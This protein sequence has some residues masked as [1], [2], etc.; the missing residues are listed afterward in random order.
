MDFFLSATVCG[1]FGTALLACFMPR[2]PGALSAFGGLLTLRFGAGV[3]FETGVLVLVG[4]L[5]A[6]ATLIAR[7]IP[8]MIEGNPDV[9]KGGQRAAVIGALTGIAMLISLSVNDSRIDLLVGTLLL[10]FL[11]LPFVTA[12]LYELTVRRPRT[13]TLQAA[14]ADYLFYLMS[15]AVNLA[16]CCYGIHALT[17]EI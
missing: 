3:G 2:I 7:R 8:Q 17:S 12:L 14:T 1:L 9:S 10:A 4:L 16:V 11:V 13:K 6:V 5:S 15:P